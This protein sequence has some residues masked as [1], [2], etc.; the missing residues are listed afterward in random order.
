MNSVH[1]GPRRQC[2]WAAAEYLAVLVGLM[3]VWYGTQATLD[4][5]EHWR[6]NFLWTLML[7]Y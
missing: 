4:R 5:L 3:T 2:G 1:T 7:P 6:T